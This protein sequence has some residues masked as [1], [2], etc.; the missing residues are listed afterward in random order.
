[1]VVLILGQYGATGQTNRPS[2]LIRLKN[3]AVAAPAN[4]SRWLDSMAV[5]G[6]LGEPVQA[7]LRFDTPP[8]AQQIKDMSLNGI[9]LLDYIPDNTYVA[10]IRPSLNRAKL[11]AIPMQSITATV[12]EWKADTYLWKKAAAA[13]GSIKVLVSIVDGLAVSALQAFVNSLGGRIEQGDMAAWGYHTVTVPAGMLRRLAGWYAVRFVSP[14]T[15]MVAL[16]KQSIP[17]VKGNA[18]GASPLWGGYGLN[19]DSVTIGVGDNTSGIYHTDVADRILNFNPAQTTN[20]GI[21]INCI[22]GG[23]AILDPLAASMTP[24]VSLINFFFS[25]VLS[26]TGAM[27]KDHNMTI[28]NNSYTV[29]ENDCDYFGTYDLYSRFLDT[30]AL[31]YPTVQHV[32]AAGNDGELTCPPH[33]P[34]YA[35]LGGGY[36]P[37]K[38]TLIVGSVWHNFQQAW[39]QSRGPVRDGR[40]KPEIVA[41]GAS[42][43]SGLRNNTY[44]WAGGTSMAAPQAASGLAVLTQRYKQLNGGSQPRADLLKAV[45]CNGAMDLGTKGPDYSYGF[46][47]MDIGRSLK[48]L[49]NGQYVSGVLGTGDSQTIKITVPAGMAQAKVLLYWNDVPAS[50]MSAR[51]LI[52]DLD[53]FVTTPAGQRHLPLGL[54]PDPARVQDSAVE[55]PDHLN[56]IEQ[57]T[58]NA[59]VP[60]EYTITVKGHS[61]PYG[62][63]H[64]VV[65]YD[66]LPKAVSLTYPLGGEQL[67]NTDSIRVFW[68]AVPDGNTYS[69][70]FS[71]DGGA[72]WTT[73]GSNMQQHAHYCGFMP[74]NVNSGRCL[75]RVSRNSTG[76]V[77]V[78]QRFAINKQ[79]LAAL[80]QSQCPGYVNLHWSPVANASAYEVLKKAGAQMVVADTVTDTTY[81]F[82]G[83]S[84]T[85]MSVV[86]VQPIINGLSG[87]RSL[88][89]TTIANHGDCLN[90][91]S[92]GDLSV[93]KI[94]APASGR[95]FTA[96][97][98]PSSSTLSVQLRNHYLSS[99]SDYTL[100]YK[101]N[102]APWQTVVS[103]GYTI[104][105]NGITTLDIPGVDFSAPGSY[106]LV[107]AITNTTLPDPQHGNDTLHYTVKC[108]P[109]DPVDLT[110]PFADGF[111][112]LPVF[113]VSRDSMGVSPDGHWDYFN[114]DDSGRLRSYLFDEVTI[115]GNRSV[116][117]DQFMPMRHGSGNM[118]A[119]TFNM[120]AYDTAADEVRVDFDYLLHGI[121]QKRAGNLVSV[122]ANDGTAWAPFYKYDLASYPGYVR[123]A[124]SLSLTDA[125]R[126]S[127]SNFTTSTQ[128]AFGQ[129]D[130]TIIAGRNYG[131]GITIDNFKMYT[132]ANDAVLAGIVSP[133]QNN[134]GLPSSV[135][136]TVKVKNGVNFTLHDVQLY[137]RLDSGTVYTGSID[138]I[139]AKDSLN[140]T[141]AQPLN[142]AAGTEH[143]VDVW[144]ATTGDSYTLNDSVLRY[145][146]RNSRIISTYPYVEH[147]EDGD[148]GFYSGGFLSSW[149]WGTPADTRI[150]TAA[151]GT[152]AWKS[153]LTGRHNSLEQSFLYS[154]CFDIS[155]LA[156]P[157][158]S[159]S[160]A[161]DLENCGGILC[162][163]AYMEYSFDGAEWSKLGTAGEGVNWY[164]AAFNTW[165]RAGFSR[166]HVATIALPRPPAGKVLH[167]RYV[168]F[169]DPAVN[170]EGIAI[171][172]I[173]LYDRQ[174]AIQPAG[175]PISLTADPASLQWNEYR[176]ANNLLAA[177]QPL[178]AIGNTSVTL[179]G[180]DTCSNL[181]QTQYVLPRSYTLATDAA[182][183]DSIRV[184]LY[185]QEAD[186]V[187]ALADT[188][189]PSCTP[190]TDAYRLGV[191]QYYNTNNRN[192]ENATLADDTGGVFVY[193]P[194]TRIT[195]LPF[196]NGYRAELS[197]HK[198]GELWFNNGGPTSAFAAGNDY[199][200]FLAFRA[201]DKAKVYW[202]S[203]I[204]TAVAGY[205]LERSDSGTV[206]EP[207]HEQIPAGKP[208]AEYTY[209][210]PTG[211]DVM[212]A[213]YYRLRWTMHGSSMLHYSPVRRVGEADVLPNLVQ[214]D[215]AMTGSNKVTVQ[216]TSYIDALADHYVLEYAIGDNNYTLLEQRTATRRYGQA[217]TRVHLPGALNS[218]TAVRYR[219]TAVLADG[220]SVVLPERTVRWIDGSMV[221]SLYPNP[222]PGG[223]F[224]VR[225]N[226]EQGAAMQL[227]VT[228]IAS[229]EVVTASAVAT[230]WDNTTLIQTGRLPAGVYLV[231]MQI[232][233]YQHTAKLVIE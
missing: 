213:R 77:A 221:T 1:V 19:G 118:L 10:I 141:F 78:S 233:G 83:M 86:A 125:V 38:N 48:I 72:N 229:R 230:A 144:L 182:V 46:G 166:W 143:Q 191:T 171:D 87:Y 130:S 167:L 30:M 157:M 220:S 139:R 203:L 42:V 109:N 170:F 180:Q 138:S 3:A 6:M 15:E 95:M 208:I 190:L 165:N 134:C 173:H 82:G 100:S 147:F 90:P 62:P 226:A 172:D 25:N 152:K 124:L 145:R 44:G 32:F 146:F 75:V 104:A 136:L 126:L 123:R 159:F 21:H 54:N 99:C 149:Q 158:L 177:V 107:V 66:L 210:D 222:A 216:W 155:Q 196:D 13:Q 137:Y 227:A 201:G 73:I 53:L 218:G 113:S 127:G 47:M 228:D 121:P 179:Y 76:A 112:A 63:Q 225:W 214:F 156:E 8:N 129:N 207:V 84:L 215:A 150:H 128:I 85:Q 231:R 169:A 206:F 153:N 195:W 197:I 40:L 192:A 102:S 17:A 51:Q 37:S 61:I 45:I 132:V 2:N 14:A 41:V 114:A 33:A 94:A 108:L 189:C 110:V 79:P 92:I 161:E 232:G 133:Q 69:V 164:D 183:T 223:S 193:Y 200:N 154:P 204:D 105:A 163:G 186:M 135:P 174:G 11:A 22:A 140:Y 224:A 60:G 88:G 55:Q 81:S 101:I 9:T 56:N 120:A 58:I 67:S 64:F 34:G 217:Y 194:Y 168:I 5:A 68:N 115:A 29:V 23:A 70:D 219:L 198:T 202:H 151:S 122:R 199:L 71:T 65:A 43:Y 188:S 211:F 185:L 93:V 142:I 35:T 148:G 119:G 59:P 205:T 12:P 178:R 39:D 26:A 117:L 80:A 175:T 36:Q 116:S 20:H 212:L 106:N 50:P 49:D 184:R 176:Y 131:A 187:T 160:M 4:A 162:D 27:L 96:S 18:A 98:L 181:T 74:V 24:K 97:A 52:N 28:T 103:P 31:Q 16:D 91:A 111:E 7:I 89:V 209:T 57:V